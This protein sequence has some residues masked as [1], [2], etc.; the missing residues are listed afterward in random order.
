MSVLS[1]V[2]IRKR[3]SNKITLHKPNFQ[4]L[5]FVNDAQQRFETPSSATK[6]VI[7]ELEQVGAAVVV[8]VGVVVVIIVII[9][10]AVYVV[11]VCDVDGN[12]TV[13]EFDQ[14]VIH[15]GTVKR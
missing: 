6:T 12:V 13:A 3:R 7:Q 9:V 8:V 11:A 14:T 2:V 1:V 10:V 4:D 5:L 15:P